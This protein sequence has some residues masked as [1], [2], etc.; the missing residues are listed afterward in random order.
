MTLDFHT[1][2]FPDKLA[3]KTI[4]HLSE[5]SGYAP[6]S[7][8]T[9]IG[10]MKVMDKCKIDKSVVCNIATNVKQTE[11][12]NRFAIEVDKNPRF[13]SFGSVHPDCDYK[14]Y[15]AL[16][17]ENG[18]KGIKLHPDYQGF[19]IDDKKMGAIY[20]E[21][22]KRDFVL[23]FHTGVDDGVGE[24]AHATP[25]RIKNVI[26]MFRNE[27][28]VLAHMGG[29]KMCEES[30]EKLIGEPIFLDTSCNEGFMPIE[31]FEKMIKEHGADRI[32]FGSDLPWTNPKVGLERV[33][34]LNISN[35]EKEMILGKNAEMLLSI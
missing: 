18:I 22:L 7:D 2:L 16:L 9:V 6:N 28:V 33:N 20:E 31:I 30:A 17:Q 35:A 13:V 12:V 5:I 8:A 23:I 10:N 24:P 14:Y 26:G 4:A 34:L 32:L 19:F 25:E 15:L 21:I 1:H 27:K 3:E 29:F 11:N